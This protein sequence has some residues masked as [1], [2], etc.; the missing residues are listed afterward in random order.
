MNNEVSEGIVMFVIGI[1]VALGVIAFVP[2]TFKDAKQALDN[3]E[4]SLSRDQ[5]CKVIA[6]PVVKEKTNVR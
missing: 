3:C 1:L 2:G 5:Y 4:V 6:V